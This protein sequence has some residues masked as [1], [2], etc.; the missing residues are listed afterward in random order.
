MS[1]EYNAITRVGNILPD[2]SLKSTEKESLIWHQDGSFWGY[3]KKH[4][5]NCLHTRIPS[6]KG[7]ETM[8]M[9]LVQATEYVK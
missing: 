5:Y 8:F 4:I 6:L 1:P 9:D 2:G 3:D 7:G